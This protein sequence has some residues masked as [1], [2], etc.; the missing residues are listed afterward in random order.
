MNLYDNS[1]GYSLF[2]DLGTKS[3]V[4]FQN[5]AMGFIKDLRAKQVPE[6][7]IEDMCLM[8]LNESCFNKL[9]TALAK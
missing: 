5:Y 6:N 8:F 3:A 7:E 9:L 1:Q 2:T 4:K